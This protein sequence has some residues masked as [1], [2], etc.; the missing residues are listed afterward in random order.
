MKK[1]EFVELSELLDML[2]QLR[3]ST[4]FLW[5]ETDDLHSAQK[6]I[7]IIINEID[8][9]PVLEVMEDDIK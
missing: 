2:K 9:L 7:D 4:A 3:K 1:V 8:A 6:T 5:N